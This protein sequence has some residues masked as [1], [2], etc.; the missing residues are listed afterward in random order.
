MKPA[1]NGFCFKNLDIGDGFL[2]DSLYKKSKLMDYISI[3]RNEKY[4][5]KITPDLITVNNVEMLANAKFNGNG[6]F[7]FV[8]DEEPVVGIA[9]L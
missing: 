3:L 9:K 6:S 8:E 1:N 2:P 5:V 4:F 7:V